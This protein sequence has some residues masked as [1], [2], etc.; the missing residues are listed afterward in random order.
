MEWNDK[1]LIIY[2]YI[3]LFTIIFIILDYKAPDFWAN[4]RL[5]VLQMAFTIWLTVEILDR[6]AR[7]RQ[8]ELYGARPCREVMHNIRNLTQTIHFQL[9]N[10]GKF[11]PTM[12]EV[13]CRS[14]SKTPLWK[15]IHDVEYLLF[16]KYEAIIRA[17]G[18]LEP[19]IKQKRDVKYFCAYSRGEIE[20]LE[21][22][23]NVIMPFFPERSDI[24]EGYLES[25][26]NMKS[27][28]DAILEGRTDNV[29][30]PVLCARDLLMYGSVVYG[31][32]FRK[33]GTK[34]PMQYQELEQRRNAPLP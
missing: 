33:I 15:Y 31:I 26:R 29:Y 27:W 13:G 25:L 24:F 9:I 4:V 34:Q 5:S 28:S 2:S 1:R 7:D 30:N 16:E 21:Y 32:L 19:T 10:S 6:L 12:R 23:T 20:R 11:D 14:P 17:E 18:K 3:G 22:Y 8:F